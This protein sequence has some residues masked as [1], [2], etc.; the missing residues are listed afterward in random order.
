MEGGG[1]GEGPH[2]RREGAGTH[3]AQGA[4]QGP[5]KG[6]R[7]EPPFPRSPGLHTGYPLVPAPL[8][9]ASAQTVHGALHAG[10]TSELS[11]SPP[12]R[13]QLPQG[14][15]VPGPFPLA[16]SP[17]GLSRPLQPRGSQ[18]WPPVLIFYHSCAHHPSLKAD[19]LV[20]VL[21]VSASFPH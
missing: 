8:K 7:L 21:G 9:P 3:T 11:P 19:M 18:G 16:L 6:G 12:T 17:T 1:P 13:A 5:G 4:L 10:L 2:G 20:C 14:L 15:T